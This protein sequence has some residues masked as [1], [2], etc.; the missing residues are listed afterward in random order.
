M[1]GLARNQKMLGGGGRTGP[2]HDTD[3][4]AG[5]CGGEVNQMIIINNLFF[6]LLYRTAQSKGTVSKCL[7]AKVQLMFK[8]SGKSI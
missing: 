3:F 8:S 1:S 5:M 6:I 2:V 7:D 4:S